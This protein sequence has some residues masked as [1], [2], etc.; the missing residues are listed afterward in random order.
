M[1]RSL[2]LALSKSTLKAKWV[3]VVDGDNSLTPTVEAAVRGGAFQ[4]EKIVYRGGKCSYG[5]D[6]KNAG[7]A[8]IK[9][10]YYHCVDDDNIVHPQFFAGLERAMT[11][12]PNKRAFVFGQQRWDNI[13]SLIASPERMEYGKIDN[14]MFAVHS[15]LIGTHRYDLSRSGREDFHFFRKLYDLHQDEF[16]FIPETLA[17]YNFMTHFPVI[18]KEEQAPPVSLDQ[19]ASP[20]VS[21]VVSSRPH[22]PGVSRIALYSSKRER[23]GIS[24]YTSQLEESLTL[25]GHDVRYFSS[26]P[27]HD[28]TFNEIRNWRPSVFHIQHESSIMPSFDV[29]ERYSSLMAREGIRVIMTLHTESD[30]TIRTARA[31]TLNAAKSIVVHR[32]TP[33]ATEAVVIPMPCTNIGRLESKAELRR[34]FGF[35]ENAFILSTVGFMIPWKDHPRIVEALLPWLESRPDVHLQVIASEHFNESMGGYANDCRARIAR[36]ASRFGEPRIHHI[37]G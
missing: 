24:T 17:Y 27:P 25:L 15:S 1:R 10:G 14:T 29:L 19:K 30:D 33:S 37:D 5:I 21:Y 36:A 22:S 31:A 13:K 8:S 23:C 32:P 35:P 16:V 20:T 18:T 4:V 26:Q 3:L 34:R 12:N 11:A 9:D 2:E 7:M 28:V 6:Q